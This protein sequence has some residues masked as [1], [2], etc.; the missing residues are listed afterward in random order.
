[1]TTPPET[2][3]D[4]IAAWKQLQGEPWMR[5]RYRVG[6]A[7]LARHL[8]TG[9][10]QVLDIGGGNGADALPLAAQGHHVTVADY[11]AAMLAEARHAADD[12]GLADQV[13]TIHA[14]LA[15][16]PAQLGPARFDLILCHNVVQY[17]DDAAGALRILRGLLR[18]S[19]VLSLITANPVSEVLRAALIQADPAAALAALTAPVARTVVFDVDVHRYD[20]AELRGW[21]EA[22]GLTVVAHY[23]IRCV[24]DYLADNARK[25]DPAFAAPLEALELALSGRDPYRQIARF[26]HLVARLGDQP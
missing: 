2:F 13:A 24:N 1:M 9:P 17:L 5:L 22:A 12:A 15:D 7:N 4:H 20:L 19:G 11:S 6:Q 10:L 25:A 23:G 18:A 14:A 8:P 21:L 26:T 16:L 3:D